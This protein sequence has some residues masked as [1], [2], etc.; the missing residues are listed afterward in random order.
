MI[1]DAP[2]YIS[3]FLLGL[4]LGVCIGQAATGS[5]LSRSTP[6]DERSGQG[7]PTTQKSE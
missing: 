5:R 4:V 2:F 7:C 6:R 1:S 3:V